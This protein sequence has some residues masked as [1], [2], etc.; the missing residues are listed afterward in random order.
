MLETARAIKVSDADTAILLPN[1]IRSYLPVRL[2][3]VRKIY[4]YRRGGRKYLVKGPLPARDDHGILPMPMV[5]YYLELCRWLGLEPPEHPAP[6]LYVPEDLSRDAGRLL[7]KYGITDQDM[8]I[9]LNPGAKFGSSKCWPPEYFARLADMLEQ[10]ACVESPRM[11]FW[12]PPSA[13]CPNLTKTA[14][15]NDFKLL[16]GKVATG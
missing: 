16:S 8:V 1:S 12:P 15:L 10:H 6:S 9:G 5:D 4:G 7:E 3:G 13:S 14:N 11:K 2:A